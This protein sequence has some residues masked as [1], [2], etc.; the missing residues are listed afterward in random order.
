MALRVSRAALRLALDSL[1]TA[2]E[3]L[4]REL[5]PRLGT[6]A[7]ATFARLTEGAHG[8]LYLNN[9]FSLMI[10]EDGFP[11]PLSHFSA[12]CRDAAYLSL[13]LA[14]LT[15]LSKDRLPLFFDEAFSHL[16][17]RR[18]AQL[19]QLLLQYCADGGQCLLFTCH[20]RERSF[21]AGEKSVKYVLLQ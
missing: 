8:R 2:A 19:L 20:T 21:L 12:G 15:A 5:L 18:T 4:R 10:E 9:E 17:D 14:L 11:R 16:D 3:D 13:R 7:A 6:V 1:Q